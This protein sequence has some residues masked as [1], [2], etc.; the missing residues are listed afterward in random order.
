MIDRRTEAVLR[1][2]LLLGGLCASIALADGPARRFGLFVGQNEGGEG[3][4]ALLYAQDDARRM[5]DVFVRLGGVK[6]D[7][8]MLLLDEKAD[9]VTI[10]LGELERRIRDAQARGERTT[11]FFYYSGHAKDGALRLGSTKL[12]LESVKQRLAS[13]PADMR[14][15]FLDACRSGTVTRTKGVRRAPAFEVETDATRQAKGLVILTSSASDE[16]SQESDLI[17]ASYFSYHLATGLLGSADAQGDGRVTLSEAYAWAYE[18]TLASTADSAAGP[19]HPTFSFDLAGNGDLVLTDVAER[20]EGLRLPPSA[21]VGAYF[22]VDPRGVVVAETVKAEGERLIAL[23][24]GKYTI[25]RRLADRLR[26]GTVE[27]V[28]GQLT[29][30]DE[31]LLQNAKFSDD[32]V[33]GTGVTSTFSR[34][35]SLS[36]SGNYQAVFDRPTSAGGYF[37]SAPLVGAEA[38][39]HNFFG[40]GFALAIDGYYGWTSGTVGGPLLGA[41]AYKYSLLTF[42]GALFYEWF[43]DARWIPFVGVHLSFNLYSREFTDTALAGQSYSTFTPGVAGGLKVRLTQNVSIIA[44]ARVH[45]LLYNVDETRSL[46]SADLGLLLDWEFKD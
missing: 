39:L 6:S 42:G 26:I 21:P 11:L 22:I 10:A 41:L 16:D 33:K 9:D 43:Q 27:I 18:R 24:P 23:A 3:T 40:R 35:W 46:G 13:G 2:L 15:A 17:G 38:T 34:H 19:Q 31:S 5:H 14:V 1:G 30:L 36:A 28:A 20:R 8:A 45:Y 37:P 32:P 7:D 25:K 12:P 4:K 29:T 44:R